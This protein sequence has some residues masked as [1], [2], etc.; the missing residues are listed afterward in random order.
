M[1]RKTGEKASI[2]NIIGLKAG[3]R[4]INKTICGLMADFSIILL[5]M[6]VDG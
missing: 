3:I 2:E 5:K 1:S 4:Q 6:L